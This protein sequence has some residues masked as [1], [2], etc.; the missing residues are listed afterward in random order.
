MNDDVNAY[1]SYY[2]TLF[3]EHLLHKQMD[4][5]MNMDGIEEKLTLNTLNSQYQIILLLSTIQYPFH[6]TSYSPLKLTA[7]K[8]ISL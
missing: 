7:R 4:I 1:F 5:D 8:I 2:D 3:W 6:D